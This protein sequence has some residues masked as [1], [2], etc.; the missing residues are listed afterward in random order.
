LR[1]EQTLKSILITAIASDR[2]NPSAIWREELNDLHLGPIIRGRKTSVVDHSPNHKRYWTEWNFF[3]VR[4]GIMERHWESAGGRS[5]SHIGLLQKRVRD[6]LD[7]LHSIPSGGRLGGSKTLQMVRQMY[8]W[9]EARSMF[10]KR[11]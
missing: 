7:E 5:T 6:V 1:R 2:W 11:C 4:N 9:F 3:A 10:D 8:S